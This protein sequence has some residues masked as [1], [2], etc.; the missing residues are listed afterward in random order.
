MALFLSANI[1]QGD[2]LFSVQ[3]RGKQCAFMSLSAVLTAQNISLIDWSTTTFNNVLLQGDKM[4]LKA[5]NNGLIDLVLPGVEFLSV[6]N[7]P[8]VVSDSCCTST[9]MLP[10]DKVEPLSV[11]NTPAESIQVEPIEAK[12]MNE[13]PIAVEPI[14]AKSMNDLPIA[15]ESIEAKSM[16][17]LPIVMEPI[18]AK[19]NIDLPV[20][21]KTINVQH[22]DA[23]IKNQ[24]WFINYGKELQGL[25]ITDREW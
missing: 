16:N 8:K 12:S 21:E 20:A 15:V 24:M 6:D 25:V 5:L 17:D 18:E 19:S 4:Y 2:E 22:H 23:E 10:Y 1:H 7:L 11:V 14:E 3:S 13:L 9:S